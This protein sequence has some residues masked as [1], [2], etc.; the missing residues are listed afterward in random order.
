ME[1]KL[2]SLFRCQSA[3]GGEF[4]MKEWIPLYDIG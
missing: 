2:Q 1:V 4:A 3:L